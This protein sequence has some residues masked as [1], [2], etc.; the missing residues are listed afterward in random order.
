M[1]KILQLTPY[2]LLEPIHGG[3]IRCAQ[4]QKALL[5]AG[6]EVCNFAMSPNAELRRGPDDLLSPPD[7][8]YGDVRFPYLFDHFA[9]QHALRDPSAYAHV[10]RIF[11]EYQPDAIIVEQPYLFDLAFRLKTEHAPNCKVIL[12]SQNVEW[13][14]KAAMPAMV[15]LKSVQDA[16]VQEI[17]ELEVRA[18]RDADLLIACTDRDAGELG[19]WTRAPTVVAPNGIEPFNCS[20]AMVA[21]WSKHFG[22]RYPVFVGS[23]HPP[24]ANGFWKM[25]APGLAFLPPGDRIVV[26]GGVSHLIPV[27][28]GMA[29][30]VQ[31]NEKRLVL[32]GVRERAD[33]QAMILA[34]H[35]VLLPI[36][37]GEGS[38]LKTAEA[39]HS[40]KWIVATKKAF[41]G[42]EFALELPNVMICETPDQFRQAVR[43]TLS[44]PPADFQLPESVRHRIE[45]E[46]TLQPLVSAVQRLLAD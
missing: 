7:S 2:P 24:N 40:G 15:E 31:L 8:P 23:A 9:G 33:L 32:A 42:Y 39:L 16:F 41:R 30:Y 35:V 19:D 44:K 43:L 37:E 12:S 20:S 5:G 21:D 4:I 13:R 28:Q 38:N 29:E 34:S 10:T 17:K 36:V 14:L 1:K 18:A 25:L 22:R 6:F 11:L 27:H 45:W 46:F 26:L 3:Q